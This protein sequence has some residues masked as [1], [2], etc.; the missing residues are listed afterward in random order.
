MKESG[1]F[2]PYSEFAKILR[3]WLIAYGIGVQALLVSTDK[4]WDRIAVSGQLRTLGILFLA[5][6]AI[7]V[8]MA[9]FYKSL[10]WQLYIAEIHPEREQTR[11]YRFA[12]KVS[13]LFWPEFILDALSIGLFA[14]ATCK[15]LFLLT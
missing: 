13:D 11:L 12:L 3:T 5:G 1:F 14:I 9:L 6:V 10:M 4:C 2:E 8:L 7:Q 15:A